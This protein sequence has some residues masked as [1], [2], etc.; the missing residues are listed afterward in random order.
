MNKPDTRLFDID[1]FLKPAKI[2]HPDGTLVRGSL[3]AIKFTNQNYASFGASS[4]AHNY[5]SN[6]TRV[7]IRKYN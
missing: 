4:L 1:L 5:S 6:S 2:K 7:N 3:R